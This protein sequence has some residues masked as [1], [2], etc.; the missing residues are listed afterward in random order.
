MLLGLLGRGRDNVGSQTGAA[1]AWN[2]AGAIAGSLAGG[3]G[4]IP[5]LTATGTWKLVA[6]LLVLSAFAAAIAEQRR[7]SRPLRAAPAILVGAVVLMMW[8]FVKGP[9]AAWR[10]AQL[11]SLK[12]YDRTPNETRDLLQSLR[13][14]ILWQADGVETSIGI[15]K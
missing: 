15:S 5:V 12:Q 13:R 9:T 3:F 8:G 1:Y 10:H 4:F 2:T 11:S 14:D 6:L 7:L